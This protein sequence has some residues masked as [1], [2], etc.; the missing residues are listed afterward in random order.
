MERDKGTKLNI[1]WSVQLPSVEFFFCFFS[2]FDERK[3]KA[4]AK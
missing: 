3:R 4:K 1:M 2:C